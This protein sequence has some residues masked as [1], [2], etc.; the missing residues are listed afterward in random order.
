ML[1][2]KLF[3]EGLVELFGKGWLQDKV[4]Y[5]WFGISEMLNIASAVTPGEYKQ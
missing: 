3:L 1:L 2:V 5:G 4:C